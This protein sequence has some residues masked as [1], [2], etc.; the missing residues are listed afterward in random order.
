MSIQ[1]AARLLMGIILFPGIYLAT[2]I[3]SLDDYG[4]EIE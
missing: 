1:K 3:V 4:E 2:L